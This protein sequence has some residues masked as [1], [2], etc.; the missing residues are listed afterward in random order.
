MTKP[1]AKVGIP[2]LKFLWKWKVATT[3]SLALRHYPNAQMASAHRKLLNLSYGGY[4]RAIH[5]DT[6]DGC[7]WSLTEKGYKVIREDVG[8]LKE[9]GYKSEAIGHDL[10]SMAAMIGEWIH[11][12]PDGVQIF[13]EQ[14]LR[15]ITLSQFPMWVPQSEIH[16]A[17]GYWRLPGLDS[18]CSVAL[19]LEKTKKEISKYELVAD[20]YEEHKFVRHVIWIAK[21]AGDRSAIE[22]RIR[23]YLR[24]NQTKHS[25]IDIREF[26]KLGWQAK[27]KI[28]PLSG[29]TLS[30]L[31]VALSSQPHRKGD[32]RL[33]LETRKKP[34]VLDTSRIL[35][36]H[37]FY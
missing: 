17:D 26:T 35:A 21:L 27:F 19:E 30:E 12:N 11:G 7:V 25:F 22:E 23:S 5:S 34:L 8:I 6:G 15:R 36:T 18:N 20:F 9:E 37:S 16:R 13:S 28:G 4:I 29:R 10:L 33:L 2:L 32:S 14:Q 1:S 31:M 3:A 24:Q